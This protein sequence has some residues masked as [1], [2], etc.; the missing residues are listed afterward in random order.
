MANSLDA[1][2]DRIDIDYDEQQ[3]ILVVKDNGKGMSSSDFEQYHDF[4][5]G[6]KKRGGGIG[7]AGVGAKISFNIAQKVVTETRGEDILRWV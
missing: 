2:A 1:G 3:K 4:A 5:A 6:L 7:F